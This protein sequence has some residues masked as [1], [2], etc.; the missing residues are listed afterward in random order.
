VGEYNALLAAGVV[1][2]ETGLRL[3]A[4]R[5]AL[6]AEASGGAM[7]AVVGLDAE[8]VEEVLRSPEL[9]RVYSANFN[10]PKQ[11]VISGPSEAVQNGEAAFLAAGAARVSQVRAR[12]AAPRVRAR[13]AAPR[14]RARAVAPR[15]KEVRPASVAVRAAIRVVRAAANRAVS[16]SR[17][18]RSTP[19]VW[20]GCCVPTAACSAS[21]AKTAPATASPQSAPV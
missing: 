6:M 10:A 11:I 12:A 16:A 13:A 1:D 5:G 18:I 17:E 7:A 2:F 3:V 4:R 19:A 20:A 21:T 14:V 15:G 8:Q 9:E